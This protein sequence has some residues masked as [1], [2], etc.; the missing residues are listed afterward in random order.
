MATLYSHT[1]ADYTGTDTLPGTF[2]LSGLATGGAT[3]ATVSSITVMFYKSNNGEYNMRCRIKDSDGN[4]GDYSYEDVTWAGETTQI[5]TFTFA[6]VTAQVSSNRFEVQVSKN[7]GPPRTT[8][9]AHDDDDTYFIVTGTWEGILP[10]DPIN[11]IP[12]HEATEI[13]SYTLSWENGGNTNTFDVYFRPFGE[14]FEKVASD[15]V[16][17]SIS[18]KEF[19]Y[20]S[21]YNYGEL[22]LWCVIAKNA[23]G[24]NH[25]PPSGFGAGYGGTIWEFNAR[26]FK[27]PLPIGVTLD[28]SGDSDDEGFGEPIGTPIGENAMLAVRRLVAA[29]NDKIWYE[30]I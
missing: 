6:N 16:G 20:G 26:T 1:F 2:Y 27:P 15:I 28:Y 23:Q 13:T 19:L 5:I 7:T 24:V 22:Y 10:G 21:H 3:H 17:L 11:P 14:F 29:A 4:W 30:S 18:I 9:T 25:A 12:I 8:Y